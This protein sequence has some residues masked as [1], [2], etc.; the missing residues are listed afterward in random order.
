MSPS[1]RLHTGDLAGEHGAMGIGSGIVID[2]DP[3]AEFRECLL[4][5]EFLTRSANHSP[6]TFH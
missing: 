4:K 1:G 3:A 6:D 2:S 5:A